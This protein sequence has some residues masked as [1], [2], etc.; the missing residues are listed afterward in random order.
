MGR[1]IAAIVDVTSSPLSLL[2]Y[3]TELW[4]PYR[5]HIREYAMKLLQLY[6]D[7]HYNGSARKFALDIQ[8]SDG[9]PSY[10][11]VKHVLNGE[12]NVTRRFA[13]HIQH[14]TKGKVRKEKIMFE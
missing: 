6:I 13:E 14:A 2:G 1:N 12:R 11:L 3:I 7:M 9:Y 8:G 4:Y 5:I 10:Q